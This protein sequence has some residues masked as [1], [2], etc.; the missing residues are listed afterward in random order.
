MFPNNHNGSNA[1]EYGL[2]VA[3]LSLAI[4]VI[5]AQAFGIYDDWQAKSIDVTEAN[6]LR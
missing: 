2:I 4:I 3:V 5:S 1:I 6:T